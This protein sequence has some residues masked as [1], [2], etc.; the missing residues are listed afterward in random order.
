MA[1]RAF[2]LLGEC[3]RHQILNE[4]FDVAVVFAELMDSDQ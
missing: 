3:S 1:V 2:L 4:F